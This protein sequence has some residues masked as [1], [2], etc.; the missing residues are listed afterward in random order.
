MKFGL[1]RAAWLCSLGVI[2]LCPQARAQEV[3]ELTVINPGARSLGLGGAFVA[4][5]DDATASY[6]NPAGL[7]QLLRPEISFEARVWD[8]DQD[9]AVTNASGVGFASFVLPLRRLSLAVYGQ[10]LTS[11][12]FPGGQ[13]D[14]TIEV[15]SDLIVVNAGLSLGWKLGESLSLGLGLT[16]IIGDFNFLGTSIDQMPPVVVVD[17]VSTSSGFIA[18]VLWDPSDSWSVGLAHRS[19]ADLD[20]GSST[21]EEGN[22]RA[23]L[24]AVTA[25]GLR[26]RSTGGR[27]TVAAE[28]EHLSGGED[29]T[30]LHLGGEWVFLRSKPV[31]GLRAGVWRDPG[32]GARSALASGLAPSE[33][34]T[35][36][37]AGVGFAF[38]SFQLDLGADFS[39]ETTTFSVSGIV[40]F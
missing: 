33:E 4:L 31:I 30:R 27:T 22:V 32:G 21:Q 14:D 3:I 35:H 26:W 9:G 1:C 23:T 5:A 15:L 19:G 13:I 10:T 16:Y 17:D 40:T 18:G 37:A 24:P 12:E 25:G 7:V 6:A 38:K 2:L 34:T 39:S 20:F 8:E 29:R 28:V 11:L 36:T